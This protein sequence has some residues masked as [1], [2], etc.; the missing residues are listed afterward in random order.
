MALAGTGA[1]AAASVKTAVDA[2]KATWLAKNKVL[3]EGEIDQMLQEIKT[4]EY[5]A[6]FAHLAPLLQISGAVLPGLTT[7]PGGG[8]VTGA[9][10]VPPGS[11]T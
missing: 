1:A 4:A 11:I 2:V 5:N 3:S 10:I 8:P 7:A 9:L 6:L